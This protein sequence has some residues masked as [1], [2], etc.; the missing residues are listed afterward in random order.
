MEIMLGALDQ[1][2]QIL[3]DIL[4]GFGFGGVLQRSED[5]LALF[6]F[7]LFLCERWDGDFR[8]V[9]GE[10][11]RGG[12]LGIVFFGYVQ[13]E[14][15]VAVGFFNPVLRMRRLLGKEAGGAERKNDE[16]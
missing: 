6:P 10:P 3:R 11:F 16:K 15:G 5:S 14:I 4:I 1:D 9:L 8:I 7:N 13:Q 2:G 12:V